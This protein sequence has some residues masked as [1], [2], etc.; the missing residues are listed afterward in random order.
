MRELLNCRRHRNRIQVYRFW[1]ADSGLWWVGR[2]C[3]LIRYARKEEGEIK[4]SLGA[5]DSYFGCGIIQ[6]L[7]LVHLPTIP[8]AYPRPAGARRP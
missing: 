3:N 7:T 8:A 4:P 2:P 1:A 5:L 6:H